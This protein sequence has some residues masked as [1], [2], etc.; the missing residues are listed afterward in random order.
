MRPSRPARRLATTQVP[1]GGQPSAVVLWVAPASAKR[2]RM[3]T[4]LPP[5]AAA[6]AARPPPPQAAG[7]SRRWTSLGGPS[8]A[9]CLEWRRRRRMR[10][11]R[12][13]GQVVGG[14]RRRRQLL[15]CGCWVVLSA[16]Q[17][18]EGRRPQRPSH[19]CSGRAG[20]PWRLATGPRRALLCPPLVVPRLI[21]QPSTS[22]CRLWT[23]WCGG[24]S[25]RARRRRARRRKRRRRRCARRATAAGVRRRA[26]AGPPVRI[27][28]RARR[29]C[30]PTRPPTHATRLHP[31]T[32]A[33][34][35]EDHEETESLADGY[36][37]VASGFASSLPS[38]I[39]T[40]SEIDLRKTSEGAD[41]AAPAAALA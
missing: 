35:D 10:R 12:W 27:P 15:P 32:L 3:R 4:P 41:H 13:G 5:T 22:A 39:E 11:S 26:G 21:N 29:L 19:P 6:A 25:W 38:G 17:L 14:H 18:I 37:S 36:A 1:G 28:G 24:A 31:A 34:E 16:L 9:T 30:L 20:L 8:T 40:P 7:A 23:K 33:Q 2:M